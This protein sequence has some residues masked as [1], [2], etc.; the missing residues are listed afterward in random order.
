M[1]F[2]AESVAPIELQ[3]C[4]NQL[5]LLPCH[6]LWNVQELLPADHRVLL[7]GYKV[8]ADGWAS[9]GDYPSASAKKNRIHG[10]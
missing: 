5:Q 10:N 4:Q 7:A 3:L 2:H 1:Q 9:D 6:V 8:I